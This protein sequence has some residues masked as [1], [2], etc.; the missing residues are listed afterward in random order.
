MYEIKKAADDSDLRVCV[1]I[2]RESFEG[3]A[4]QFGLTAE[5]APSNAAFITF[6]RLTRDCVNGL[7]MF[8]LLDG[9][10]PAGTVGVKKTIEGDFFLEKLGVLPDYRHQGYGKVLVEFIMDKVLSEGGKKIKIGIIED[11]S[12]LKKWYFRM[13]FD[14][15]GTKVFPHLPFIVGYMERIL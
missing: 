5:N 6:E 15:T 7:Q 8:I 1:E 2:L 11:N 13:G 3:I 9:G 10:V 12:R 4:D 14:H